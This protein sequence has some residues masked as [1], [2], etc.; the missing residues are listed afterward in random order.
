LAFFESPDDYAVFLIGRNTYDKDHYHSV[1]II[2]LEPADLYFQLSKSEFEYRTAEQVKE[3]LI[4]QLKDFTM[5]DK[6]RKSF[7][8]KANTVI[9][10][11]N[12]EKIGSK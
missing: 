6:F 12:G 9:T 2:D 10:E 8:T 4:T 1:N 7:F 11:F 5:P 3:R